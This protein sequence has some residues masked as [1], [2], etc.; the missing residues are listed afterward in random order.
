MQIIT[1]ANYFRTYPY[2][3]QE[4]FLLRGRSPSFLFLVDSFFRISMTLSPP[5]KRQEHGKEV[6]FLHD[7]LC[8]G[9]WSLRVFSSHSKCALRFLCTHAD[10]NR[11]AAHSSEEVGAGEK[12]ALG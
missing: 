5:S 3:F 6:A 11:I 8:A 7:E 2:C 12:P 10:P 4:V 9:H 1:K